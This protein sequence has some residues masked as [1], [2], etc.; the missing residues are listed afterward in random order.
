MFNTGNTVLDEVL[1]AIPAEY[2]GPGGAFA[3]LRD[4]EVLARHAWGYADLERHIPMTVE[5]LMPMCSISKE[6]TCAALLDVL[7]DPS[8]LDEAVRRYLPRL[9]GKVPRAADLCNNQSGLRDYWA[10]TVLSGASPQGECRAEDGKRLLSQARTTHFDPG[11]QY[12]YANGNFRILSDLLAEHTGRPL[13]E[14]VKERIFAPAQ[15][16]TAQWCEESSEFP[17][18]AV[19]Y[20]GSMATGHFPAINKIHLSGDSGV[21][22]SLE[23][24]IAWERFVDATR[25][26]ES[27]IYRRISAPTAFSD[28]KPACYSFGLRHME[29]NGTAMTGHG[30]ALRGWRLQ[31]RYAPSERLSVVVMFN[32]ESPASEAADKITAAALRMKHPARRNIAVDPSWCGHYIDD[33]DTKLSLT[34]TVAGPGKIKARFATMPDVM[35]LEDND[36]ARSR[37]MTLTRTSEGMRLERADENLT[38]TMRKLGGAAKA[39]IAGR[40]YSAE[41]DAELVCED[42]GGELYVA[43]EGFLG[44]GAM[45]PIYSIGPGV[46]IMP[47][48]RAMDS[49]AP[50]DWTMVIRRDGDG[51]VKQVTIG[52]WLARKVSFDKR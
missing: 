8:V 28:G 11:S 7:G 49:S 5:T 19:G 38:I 45:Q 3:V 44:K 37:L 48:E 9:E 33:E 42:A 17:G 16:K 46:W 1:S 35:E 32:H 12:S 15:M 13:G 47:N 23:D 4:G 41:L 18:D 36:T 24:M 14:W 39:D 34:V 27:S 31:R 30:G 52:C 50:G 10:L 40:Y 20:E 2:R 51:A 22:A 29:F 26:D 43:F 6:F 25:D 21:N